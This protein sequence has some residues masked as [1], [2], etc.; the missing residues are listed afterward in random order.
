[1]KA[2]YNRFY[3]ILDE[4]RQK[5]GPGTEN[6]NYKNKK[7]KNQRTNTLLGPRILRIINRRAEAQWLCEDTQEFSPRS[8]E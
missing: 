2:I 6:R 8:Y 1:M 5:L 3:V 4:L 7:Q